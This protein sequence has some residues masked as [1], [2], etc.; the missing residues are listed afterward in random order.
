MTMLKL[1]EIFYG[2]VNCIVRSDHLRGSI[3]IY[4]SIARNLLWMSLDEYIGSTETKYG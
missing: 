1:Q 3:T 4:A 2:R